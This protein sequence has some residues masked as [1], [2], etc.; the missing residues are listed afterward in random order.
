MIKTTEDNGL[1]LATYIDPEQTTQSDKASTIDGK[2]TIKRE[3]KTHK[4]I[5]T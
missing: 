1:S 5:K 3:N 4:N 2:K